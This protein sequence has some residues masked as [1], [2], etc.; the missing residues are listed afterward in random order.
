MS[1]RVSILY[2][3]IPLHL[4]AWRG[5]NAVCNGELGY[6]SRCSLYERKWY[7]LGTFHASIQHPFDRY[8]GFTDVALLKQFSEKPLRKCLRIN[9]LKLPVEDFRAYALKKEWKIEPVMWCSEGF[10][11]ERDDRSEAL[12]KDLLHMLGATY[13]QEASSMLPVALL[14]PQQGEAI[15]DMAA[16]PGSKSTQI[17]AKLRGRGVLVCNDMQE[18]RLATLVTALHRSG[19]TNAIV[20]KKVGQWFAKHMT[21]RFDRV[22]IDAPCTGQGTSRKD[23]QAL[24]YCSKHS[25]G[26]NAK[27]QRELLEAA[28]HATKVGGRIVYSTCTLTPEENEE[29]VLAILRK[30]PE[31]LEVI[32]PREIGNLGTFELGKAIDDSMLV[33]KS[34]FP[35]SLLP[36]FPTSPFPFLRIW[37]QTYDTE[38]FFCAVLRK[39]APTKETGHYDKVRSSETQLPHARVLDI[40]SYLTSRYGNPLLDEGEVLLLKKERL[41]LATEEALSFPL[42]ARHFTIGLPF[43]RT[44]TEAP[45]IL[46]HDAVTLRGHLATINVVDLDDAQWKLLTRGGDSGCSH[47]VFGHVLLRYKGFSVGRGRAKDGVLK[48][49]LPRWMVQILSGG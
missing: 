7:A 4:C 8:A 24:T 9:T 12:G 26:K 45:L 25:I 5:A 11:I 47:D 35:I 27:L 13:M 42:P 37:P 38:G 46:D 21:E 22:L 6:D 1:T 14:D 17:A 32:D 34:H 3:V 16:A 19:V 18:R 31:Q 15:L 44:L 48:N 20:T 41:I 30:F 43:G 49:Q 10:F 29:V 23:A 2:P 40:A 36:H 33:Q 28:I 39:T